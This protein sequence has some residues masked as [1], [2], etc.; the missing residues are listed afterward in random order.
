MCNTLDKTFQRTEE[1]P[2]KW[3]KNK[4]AQ[5]THSVWIPAIENHRCICIASRKLNAYMSTAVMSLEGAP[6]D[7][8]QST[9]NT[10]LLPSSPVGSLWALLLTHSHPVTSY[11]ILAPS[12]WNA[13]PGPP[14]HPLTPP[15]T[16]D[17]SFWAPLQ[18][19]RIS[20]HFAH[21]P[22]QFHHLRELCA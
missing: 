11:C 7:H 5:H 3:N 13:S 21:L 10:L 4:H 16:P 8:G 20:D 1:N 19:G 18:A 17:N 2:T 6:P 14:L 22:S 9:I 15:L 12:P